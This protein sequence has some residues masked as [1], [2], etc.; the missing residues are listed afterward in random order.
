METWEQTFQK[1]YQKLG[2][3]FQQKENVYTW[4]HQKTNTS[5]TIKAGKKCGMLFVE[6]ENTKENVAFSK[7]LLNLFKKWKKITSKWIHIK[8]K[9]LKAKTICLTTEKYIQPFRSYSILEEFTSIR[10]KDVLLPK[11]LGKEWESTLGYNTLYKELEKG[12]IHK[13]IKIGTFIKEIIEK[14]GNL[15]TRVLERMKLNEKGFFIEFYH[16]GS[17]E[18]ITIE[19]INEQFILSYGK[20]R[21]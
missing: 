11:K 17:I 8:A 15:T 13:V 2:I 3:N 21:S 19:Y 10:Y 5:M 16:C 4:N 6:M 7:E 14:K 20:K 1:R 12:Y 9:E 18:E